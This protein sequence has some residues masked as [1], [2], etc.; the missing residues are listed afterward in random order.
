M[1]ALV[2][3]MFGAGIATVAAPMAWVIL[4]L[5]GCVR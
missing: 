4:F 3:L 2:F 1:T 5:R